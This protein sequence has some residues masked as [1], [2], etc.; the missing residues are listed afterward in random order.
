ME[1]IV[2]L[3]LRCQLRE[4]REIIALCHSELDQVVD[5]NLTSIAIR[6]IYGDERDISDNVLDAFLSNTCYTASVCISGSDVSISIQAGTQYDCCHECCITSPVRAQLF[7]PFREEDDPD[8]LFDII[9]IWR[10]IIYMEHK[11]DMIVM[12]ADVIFDRVS[13]C[14]DYD[15]AEIYAKSLMFE[16][17]AAIISA[18]NSA[19]NQPSANLPI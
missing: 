18:G 7:L 12:I 10:Y 11:S 16:I 6:Y 3:G 8:Y 13:G 4:R 15:D 19:E 14:D 2:R 9:D 17:R 5:E 1:E